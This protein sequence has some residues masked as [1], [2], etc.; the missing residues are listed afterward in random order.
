M[1]RIQLDDPIRNELLA[2]RRTNLPAKVRDR[3]EMVLLADAGW[4]APRSARHLGCHHPPPR[5]PQVLPG[6]GPGDPVPR[7]ARPGAGPGTPPPVQRATAATA[8][9]AQAGPDLDQPAAQ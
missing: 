8:A 9:T 2:L 6:A 4:S 5:R 1:I 7:H 3:L